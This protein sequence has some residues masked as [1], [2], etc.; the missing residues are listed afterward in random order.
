ML[1]KKESTAE[2]DAKEARAHERRLKYGNFVVAHH[3]VILVVVVLLLIPSIFGYLNTRMNF[4]LLTYL[5]ESF[6]T[7]KGQNILLDDF[8][9]GAFSF[10]VVEDM[11]SRPPRKMPSIVVQPI[12]SPSRM[13][14]TN[15][16]IHLMPAISM[17]P[18]PT[19]RSFLKLNSSPSPNIRNIM[20]MSDHCFTADML[21]IPNS[22]RLGLIRKPAMMYPR[23]EGCLRALHMIVKIP[24]DI[25]IMARS[26]A[27]FNSSLICCC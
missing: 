1:F 19:L 10:I 25:K 16:P 13:P 22:P 6:E 23:M 2:H 17:A 11:D 21:D 24:A 14:T 8:G 4:D 9:K 15:I 18:L 20:P 12:I 26:L 27:K 5:P 7:V 3:K